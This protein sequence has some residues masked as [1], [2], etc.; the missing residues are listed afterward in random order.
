MR[1]WLVIALGMLA[2]AG[3]SLAQAAEVPDAKTLLA[4]I[5]GNMTFSTRTMTVTMTSVNERRTR[6]F[7]MV[8]YGKGED[9]ASIEYKAP[10][11]EA[12]TKMLRMG[13]EL[14]MYMPAVEKTQKI[15]GHML[16]QGMMGTDVSYEDMMAAGD[17]LSQYDAKV[18]GAEDCGGLSA[19]RSCWKMELIAKDATVSYPKRTTWIDQEYGTLARQDLYALSGMLLKTWEMTDVKDFDSGKRHFPTKMVITDKLQAG[20]STTLTMTD[21]N[22]GVTLEDEVFSTRWL[23]RTGP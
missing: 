4:K 11:R 15:S 13:D 18:I 14:W 17:L 23:E 9:T 3:S 8:A 2:L 22:F 21:I 7:T 20:T 16:R 1:N 10:A 6:S 5:D 12:G 19:G